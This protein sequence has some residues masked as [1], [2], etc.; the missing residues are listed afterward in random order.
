MDRQMKKVEK[1]R[2]KAIK[3]GSKKRERKKCERGQRENKQ[4]IE[5]NFSD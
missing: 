1:K 5:E 4:K 2:R 3:M